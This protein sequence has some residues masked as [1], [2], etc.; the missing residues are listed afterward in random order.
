MESLPLSVSTVVVLPTI[1][2]CLLI[3]SLADQS[4]VKDIQQKICENAAQEYTCITKEWLRNKGTKARTTISDQLSSTLNQLQAELEQSDLYEN[5]GSRKNVLNK[6]FPKTLVDKVGLETLMQ[7]L[8]EQ[9]SRVHTRSF[10]ARG[11][12]AE[13]LIIVPTGYLVRLG[14]FPLHLRV[15]YDCFQRR[16]L[17]LFLK[18]LCLNRFPF[19]LNGHCT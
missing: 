11:T 3:F 17:P 16:L 12:S 5:V 8:P 14:V 19:G 4:Y 7:R 18:T 6:A 1:K 10:F 9:V 2:N 15:R 13:I